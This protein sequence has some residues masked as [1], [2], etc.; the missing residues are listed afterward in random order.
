VNSPEVY[1]WA[2]V[3]G[4]VSVIVDLDVVLFMYI[5]SISDGEL[6]RFRN[7]VEIFRDYGGFMKILLEKGI[8]RTGL[9]THPLI[10]LIMI[11]VSFLLFRSFITPV[12]LGAVSHL[13]ADGLHVMALSKKSSQNG[14]Q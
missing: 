4:F 2:L 8:L 13:F 3:G 10:S 12:I 7:P 11:L 1:Y 9:K 14:I 5:R 6:R